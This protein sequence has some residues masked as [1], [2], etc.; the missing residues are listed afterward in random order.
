MKRI[1]I[2]GGGFAGV[3]CARKLRRLLPSS[4][5]YEIVLFNH[6]NHTVFHPLLA[7]V[8]SAAVQP[9]DVT[10]P[11]RQL[12]QSVCCRTEDVLNI[13][14][15][16]SK[17]EYEA[18]NGTRREM[19]FDHLVIACGKGANL[20]QVPGMDEHAFAFKTIGDAVALQAHIM[21]QLEKAEVCDDAEEKKAYLS[22]V[23]V[24]GGFSGV[25][26][27]GEINDLVRRSL[28]FFR[29]IRNEDV[30]VTV[31]HSHDSIL[32]EVTPSLREFA[33]KK[34]EEQRVTMV[35][36]AKAMRATS[37]GIALK[38]GRFIPGRTIVCTVGTIILPIIARLNLRKDKDRLVTEPDLSLP[39]HPNIWA[40]GD[41]AAIINAQDGLLSPPIA[42]F[43]ERQGALAAENIAARLNNQP[44]KPFSYLMLGH[45]CSI[46]GHNAVAEI[47]NFRISGFAAWALW[48]GIYLMKLPSFGQK[49]QVG[50]EWMF[51][52]MFP[53]CL[54][55]LKADRSNRVHRAFYAAGDCVFHEGDAATDFYVIQQGEVEILR[56]QDD[57]TQEIV[58][59]LGAGDFFGEAALIDAR[60]RNAT[61]RARTDLEI[62]ALGRSVFSQMST[63]LAPLRDA[64]ASAVKRRSTT[65][66][67]L[68]EFHS[69]VDNIPL[70]ALMEPLPAVPFHATDLVSAAISRVN[71]ERLDFCCVM[72]EQEQL[73]GILTRSDL[74]RAV[75]ICVRVPVSE[76]A[77]LQVKDI[78]VTHP[79]ALTADESSTLAILTMREHGL[80]RLPLLEN[81][82]TK[83]VCGYVRI[84]NLMETIYKHISAAATPAEPV[85]AAAGEPDS[86]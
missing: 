52:L 80:K 57:G 43:A 15:E 8:V 21:E 65:W 42:Q 82:A 4:A 30:S 81:N 55:H 76:R 26:V 29:Y 50:L 35:L 68:G 7:E 25:E 67:N 34:M 61:V 9:K 10:A 12:M 69:V 66:K 70:R 5:D 19:P 48:R 73:C 60:P 53:R 71:E 44:T 78:M 75:E 27:A 16:N 45:L 47:L 6:E 77:G 85:L 18:H 32:P 41:C 1:I 59:V 33:R 49:V 17:I 84:E 14:V 3:K 86:H 23:I 54:A 24:G 83:R 39:E 36:S 62:V 40:I 64:V 11:I 56:R 31:V 37:E 63:A 74:L 38:D 20:G 46:G 22:F 58:A 72:N 51:D 28:K 13:D 79:I 2:H